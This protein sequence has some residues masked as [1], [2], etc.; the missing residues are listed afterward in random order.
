[1]M[2]TVKT[3]SSE[4]YTDLEYDYI[5]SKNSNNFD[6]IIVDREEFEQLV[7]STPNDADLGR[8]VRE[9]YQKRFAE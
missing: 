2:H 1:M 3:S 5:M 4:V 6:S 9:F 8:I 7:K